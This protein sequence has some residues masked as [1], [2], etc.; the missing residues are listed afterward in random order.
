MERKPDPSSAGKKAAP[1][2]SLWGA[3][4]SYAAFLIL[5]RSHPTSLSPLR[6]SGSEGQAELRRAGK[7][8]KNR[9]NQRIR[10]SGKG[11][12]A[13]QRMQS[14][15]VK[16]RRKYR[17]KKH[18]T[19]QQRASVPMVEFKRSSAPPETL[20]PL[21]PVAQKPSLPTRP[22]SRPSPGWMSLLTSFLHRS[23]AS[24]ESEEALK[25]EGGKLG[26]GRILSV[27]EKKEEEGLSKKP[28]EGEDLL[29]L[30]E[31][32]GPLKKVEKPQEGK[33]APQDVKR[34]VRKEAPEEAEDLPTFTKKEA[35]PEKQVPKEMIAEI[36]KEKASIKPIEKPKEKVVPK[37]PP[38][39]PKRVSIRTRTGLKA[40]LFSIK[41]MGLGRE[42][43]LFVENLATMLSAGLPL[44]D[45]LRTLVLETRNR[46]MRRLIERI[47]EDVESGHPLWRAMEDQEFF[48]P[49]AIALI[50][51]GEEAGNLAEN[52]EYLAAQEEKDHELK[53]K[54]KMAMIYPTIVL[55]LMFI[56]VVGLGMF[57][58]P[59]LIGV[60]Y[61]LNVE[62]PFITRLIIM[63]TNVF[64]TY[65][66]IGIPAVIA[67]FVLLGFLAKFTRL[68]YV[69][70]WFLFRVPG[71]GRLAREATIARFGVIVGGLLRAGV[72]VIE[73]LQSL[74]D[75]T[76]V[77]SYKRLYKHLLEHIALGDSFATSFGAIRG[78]K[79]L[80]P[81][82]V[83]QLIV[84]GERSGALSQIMLKV[85][86]IYDKKASD[87]A[88]K[89]PIILEPILLLLIGG[90]VG[91]IA[92]AIIIPIYSIVG[93]VGG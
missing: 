77:L 56:I 48:S 24:P 5:G 22:L 20:L 43:T 57:V 90:M 45:S 39:P 41:Y 25:R 2:G 61:S 10:M 31:E 13:Q 92:F 4:K 42:R 60:L 68:T 6:P 62:L 59:N 7:K 85:A 88:Q 78:S 33:I 93:K 8:Q 81:P 32:E 49:H 65:G 44:V 18:P 28:A 47:I 3:L 27:S 30:L 11:A 9:K 84:T 63:F 36:K 38:S 74:V 55:V 29:S 70:Q 58:L 34:T 46:T 89:L 73:A 86:D 51:I 53:Q 54:V 21:P 71:I 35:V 12:V 75:V 83:Q 91:T 52:A 1:H 26:E 72:P 16:K 80:L 76:P 87:T 82:S 17:K 79:K 64:T 23:S 50:R 19:L 67:G 66:K 15:V 37:E 40:F 14:I 69:T